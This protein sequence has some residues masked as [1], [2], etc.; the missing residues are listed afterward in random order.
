[1]QGG[2]ANPHFAVCI[3]ETMLRV[4]QRRIAWAAFERASR[5]AER[6]W[7]DATKQQFLRDHC[8]KRQ[9]LIEET[10][11]ESG[12]ELRAAFDAEL[13]AGERYQREYQEYEAN[14]IAG[15][16]NIHD[17]HFFDDFNQSH[18]AIATPPGLEEWLVTER[19]DY[20]GPKLWA[21][22]GGL[23]AAGVGAM[24]A[25]LVLRRF[26][27]GGRRKSAPHDDPD[28]YAGR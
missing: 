10:L 24:L 27:T 13:A 8:A 18:P 15:G 19:K 26:A 21:A 12:A 17:E 16:A 1:M 22:A 20:A 28:G 5:L 14:K 11:G 3:G 4:G 7:P 2:G 25:A 9:K 6:Y 23:F